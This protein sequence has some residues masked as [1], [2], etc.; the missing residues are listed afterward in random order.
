MCVGERL[1]GG[2]HS[3][4]GVDRINAAVSNL[5]ELKP[6]DNGHPKVKSRQ[7]SLD[8]IIEILD[9][10]QNPGAYR[11]CQDVVVDRAAIPCLLALSR[12][13]PT[14]AIRCKCMEA[15]SRLAFANP[16]ASE[17]IARDDGFLSAIEDALQ[18]AVPQQL[19]SLQLTQAILASA[20]PGS[21][22]GV[23]ALVEGA[24]PLLL[25]SSF[26]VLTQMAMEVFI[27]A[28]FH[29]PESVAVALPRSVL[30]SLLSE[31]EH[32]PAW[33]PLDSTQTLAA[34][35]LAT[36]ILSAIAVKKDTNDERCRIAH[37]LKE[38]SFLPFLSCAL[39]AAAKQSEWPAGS[40]TF[41]SPARTVAV[42]QRLI[43]H[44]FHDK[45]VGVVEHLA[46]VV[47]HSAHKSTCDSALHALRDLSQHFDCLDVLLR[48]T[49]FRNDVLQSLCESVP[50]EREAV[51]LASYLMTVEDMYEAAEQTLGESAHLIPHAPS[52]RTLAEL[53]NSIAP[54]DREADREDLLKAMGRIPIGPMAAVRA[55]F[56]SCSQKAFT[57][58]EFAMRVYGTPTILGWWPSLME[59]I[60]RSWRE[61]EAGY[62]SSQYKLPSL[63][64]MVFL[65]EQG[66]QGKS[67]IP[68]ATILERTLPDLALPVAG[69]VVENA[70]A[71]IRGIEKLEL[72]EFSSWL[73][74]LYCDLAQE[75]REAATESQS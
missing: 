62:S 68:S 20:L 9:H 57:F 67:A 10:A 27:S 1:P 66:A 32:R 23:P 15:L 70:F 51:E 16:K 56:S 71:D 2:N 41:H 35:F 54:L 34:G 19:A 53:F 63:E 6:E 7:T 59:D 11:I 33:W 47:E 46:S 29:D 21:L 36:N 74:Q 69:T 37:K 52:V 72:Q 28:S 31:D 39:D 4:K 5:T 50:E 58:Q 8:D 24:A 3:D 26:P 17:A 55:S 45:L 49:S 14:D 12:S 18:A 38:G 13:A 44:C 64:T 43:D 61:Q 48:M 73:C 60:A 22:V 40:G 25:A 65:F 42:V 75:E 30:L